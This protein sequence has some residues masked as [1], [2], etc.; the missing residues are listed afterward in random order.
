M[1]APARNPELEA[2]AFADFDDHDA[3]RVYA[4][5]LLS[6]GDPHGEL[7]S[8]D[9]H[10]RTGFLSEQRRLKSKTAELGRD[11]A[12]RFAERAT[13]Q[14]LDLRGVE[15]KFK[16]GFLIELD[17]RFAKLAPLLDTLFEQEP[18]QRLTLSECDGEA[19]VEGL[20][21][22]PPWLS[23]L[24]YLKLSGEVGAAGCQALVANALPR[25]EGLNLL[26]AEIDGEA[27]RSL[28]DLD[29]QILRGL[30]LTFNPI[31]DDALEALLEAP[32]RSQWRR[33]YLSSTQISG[34]GVGELCTV[35]GLDGL[36]FLAL[37]ETEAGLGDFGRMVD[38]AVLP[39]LKILDLG[40]MNYWRERETYDGLHRRFG[41]GLKI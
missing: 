26:G 13:Q 19:L 14:G 27:C 17:G 5:W 39:G 22:N 29:T 8:L 4:D 37:R 24:R 38:P 34:I 32:S 23:Q 33:L 2:A 11:F 36:E 18:I 28:V 25:L 40:S 15:T 35:T 16:R 41:A 1:T 12:A 6:V 21:A 9:L 3:W 31:D 10:R 30:T 20:A 7:V